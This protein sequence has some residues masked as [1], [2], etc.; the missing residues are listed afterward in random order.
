MHDSVR[1]STGCL[2]GLAIMLVAPAHADVVEFVGGGRVAGSLPQGQERTSLTIQLEG[3]GRL[4]LD[5]DQIASVGAETEAMVEYR[6][7]APTAPDTVASQWALAKWCQENRL[8]EAYRRHL[9]RVVELDPEHAEARGLLGYQR[10]AGRW[11]SREQLMT[12]RGMIRHEGDYRTRQEILLVEQAKKLKETNA[13]WRDRL[14]RWR[15]NLN[16]RDPTRAAEALKGFESLTDP[17]AGPELANLLL[18]EGDYATRQLLIRTAAQVRHGATATALS[19]LALDDPDEETRYACLEHLARNKTPGLAEP[20]VRALKSKD[21]GVVNRAGAAL[22]ELGVENAV[23]ALVRALVTTHKFLPQS[24]AVGEQT[25]T[26]S[27]GGGRSGGGFSFGDNRPKPVNRD[28]R[29]AKVL[30]A[31]VKITGENFGY[32]EPRWQA[33]LESMATESYVDLRRDE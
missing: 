7:R 29:N 11:L 21:N 27:Q 13:D 15:R 25:Y 10:H 26:M 18:A 31:L 1:N 24:T 3:G 14:A 30:S 32:D 5:R 9:G 4:T 12:S 23:P 17:A 8:K 6:K 22:E 16:D 2:I 19:K 28:V 20:F 33:W